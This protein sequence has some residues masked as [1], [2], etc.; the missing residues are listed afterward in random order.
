M[1]AQ[2]RYGGAVA[3][4]G[5]A[6]GADLPGSVLPFILRGVTLYGI[7]SVMAP[8]ERRERAW[9]RLAAGLDVA[10]LA[11]IT[12]VRPLT[13]TIAV[14]NE[15]LAGKVRGRVVIDTAG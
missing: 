3:A 10:K 5:L 2:T 8:R 14:A 12:N 9:A 1:L 13:E 11:A 6:Q 4:C 7:D 15:L